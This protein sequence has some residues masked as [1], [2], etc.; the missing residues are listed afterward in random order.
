MMEKKLL[1]R[2]E[3]AIDW[4]KSEVKKDRMELNSEKLKM[5]E[6]IKT[7]KKDEIIAKK[8]KLTL[9]ERIKKVLVGS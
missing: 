2:E 8:E 6:S 3:Q 1:T 5:I 7:H 4:L 9:W